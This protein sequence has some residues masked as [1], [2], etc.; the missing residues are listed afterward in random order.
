MTNNDNFLNGIDDVDQGTV[1]QTGS[2]YPV[3][4]WTNGKPGNK[5]AGDIS[6]T[7]G[8][9]IAADRAPEQMPEPWIKCELVHDNGDT[10]QGWTTRALT[11][12]MVRS[13]ATWFF[14]DEAGQTT[15]VP[16]DKWE[17][18]KGLRGKR[19]VLVA[20]KGLPQP[21]ALTMRGMASASFDKCLKTFQRSVIAPAN[22]LLKDKGKRWPYRAFWITLEP[23][24][25]DKA[26]PVFTEVG[27]GQKAQ[28]ITL[29]ACDV[30]DKALTAE[31]LQAR[32]V[33]RELLKETEAWYN[34]A[35]AWA[36]QWDKPQASDDDTH[37]NGTGEAE[38]TAEPAAAMNF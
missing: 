25:N 11:V 24:R 20:V 3:I 32:F 38:A 34:D 5:K 8:W 18:N 30:P 28:K 15:Y 37:G 12:A 21:M 13:R 4:Q 31:Q 9:F 7:G 19:Q 36:H 17:K 33:G 1:E 2:Q 27:K 26:E 6:Y 35:E 16:W 22:G 29:M 23:Q 10:T 14:Q